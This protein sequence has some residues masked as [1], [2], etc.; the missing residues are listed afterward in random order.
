MAT[1]STTNKAPGVYIQEI[2]VP[3]PIPGVST[4]NAAFVGPAAQG[5]LLTPTKLTDI[6]QF[7]SIFGDYVE[8]PYRVFA[9]HAVNGFFAEGGQL[10]YFVRVGTGKQAWLNL[11]DRSG[12]NR[13][14][15]VVTA[16]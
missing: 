8:D 15:L 2:A 10:C 9:A 12:K 16:F 11:Q 13:T 5:P 14:A 6:T 3:G 1:F 7:T 4:S